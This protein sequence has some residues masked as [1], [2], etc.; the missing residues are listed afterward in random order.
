MKIGKT[1]AT[2]AGSRNRERIP[3]SN[4]SRSPVSSLKGF[5]VLVSSQEALGV[6]LPFARGPAQSTC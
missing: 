5:D 2:T 3:Q 1:S 6:A 4:P